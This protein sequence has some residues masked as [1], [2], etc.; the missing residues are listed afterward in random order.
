MEELLQVHLPAYDGP[1][2]L[3]LDLIRK[4]QIDIYDIPIASITEQYLGYLRMME[5]MDINLAGEFLL[6]AATLILI[7]SRMLLPVDPLQAEGEN[8]D[9][10]AE[11]VQR[12]LEHEKFKN[13]AQMLHEKQIVE[14][15]TW[16][17]PGIWAFESLSEEPEI[18][19]TLFDL[20]STFKKVLEKAKAQAL[21]EV[22]H[23]EMTIAQVIEKIRWLFEQSNGS[24]SLEEIF[25]VFRSKRN[26]IV[27]FLAILE[28]AYFKAIVLTQK[29]TFGEILAR[30][31]ANFAQVLSQMD[32]WMATEKAPTMVSGKLAIGKSTA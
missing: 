28:M 11:L 7:K 16:T 26:L 32:Q 30:R 25:L 31:Q 3:L 19:V 29:K 24:I 14:S 27:A 1:L 20:I 21:Y 4:Q 17:A 5:E 18:Q 2:D 13:A 12:L 23:D 22:G 10:R 8:V 6:M 15:S 9:P